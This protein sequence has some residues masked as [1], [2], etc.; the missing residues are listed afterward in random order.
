MGSPL[1]VRRRAHRR[2]VFLINQEV[3]TTTIAVCGDGVVAAA[4]ARCVANYVE[5]RD[6]THGT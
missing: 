4:M 2:I 3:D 5:S 1:T 6:W